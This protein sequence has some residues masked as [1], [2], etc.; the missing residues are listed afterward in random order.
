MMIAIPVII[1]L[2]VSSTYLLMLSTSLG[3]IA[4]FINNTLK[5]R[6]EVKASTVFAFLL[7]FIFCLDVVGA[8][9]LYNKSKKLALQSDTNDLGEQF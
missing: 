6:W 4:Y 9:V 5:K 2:L 3:D 7:L 8:I 1:A